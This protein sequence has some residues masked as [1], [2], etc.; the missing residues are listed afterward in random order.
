MGGTTS[1]APA[2]HKGQGRQLLHRGRFFGISSLAAE[3]DRVE[4]IARSLALR[5]LDLLTCLLCA[6]HEDR[7]RSG[8]AINIRCSNWN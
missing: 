6:L 8:F 2:G 3:L 5:A 7:K 1:P 4:T